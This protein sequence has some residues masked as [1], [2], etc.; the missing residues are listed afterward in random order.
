[1]RMTLKQYVDP[2]ARKFS[3]ILNL[4]KNE[5]EKAIGEEPES[6]EMLSESQKTDKLHSLAAEVVRNEADLGKIQP[7]LQALRQAIADPNIRNIGLMGSYGAGKSTIMKTFA[8]QSPEHKYLYLS[9]ATLSLKNDNTELGK[10]RDTNEML[11]STLVKQMIYKSH[12]TRMPHSRINRLTYLGKWKQNGLL[13]CAF[14]LYCACFYRLN[15]LNIQKHSNEIRQRLNARIG[16]ELAVWTQFFCI[17]VVMVCAGILLYFGCKQ[18]LSKLRITELTIFK[19]VKV[20]FEHNRSTFYAHLDEILSFFALMKYDVVV[21]EDLD[22]F[23]NVQVFEH[24][25]ELNFLLNEYEGIKRKITFIYAVKDELFAKGFAANNVS[26]AQRRT[27]FFDYIIPIAPVLNA[28][29]ARNFLLQEFAPFINNNSER[30]TFVRDVSIYIDDMRILKNMLAEYEILANALGKHDRREFQSMFS[31]VVY[32]VLCP[33]DYAALLKRKGILYEII[34][35]DETFAKYVEEELQTQVATLKEVEHEQTLKIEKYQNKRLT[36]LQMR[37]FEKIANYGELYEPNLDKFGSLA[38]LMRY[39]LINDLINDEYY[40]YMVRYDNVYLSKKDESFLRSLKSGYRTLNYNQKIDDIETIIENLSPI[41]YTRPG[42]VIRAII[43]SY[44]GNNEDIV[45]TFLKYASNEQYSI[46]REILCGDEKGY[47]GPVDGGMDLRSTIKYNG[48]EVLFMQRVFH[49]HENIVAVMKT[50]FN[51]VEWVLWLTAFFVLLQE[52]KLVAMCQQEDVK[53]FIEAHSELLLL[54]QKGRF[55]NR[56]T[57]IEKIIDV[58][59]KADIQINAFDFSQLDEEAFFHVIEQPIFAVNFAN[60]SNLIDFYNEVTG[61]TLSISLQS[62]REIDEVLA[63]YM[64]EHIV[65]YAEDVLL[66]VDQLNEVEEDLIT[67]I[68]VSAPELVSQF[69]AKNEVQIEDLSKIEG[70][71]NIELCCKYDAFVPT[72]ENIAFLNARD[73]LIDKEKLARVLQFIIDERELQVTYLLKHLRQ[74]KIK[75]EKVLGYVHLLGTDYQQIG[76]VNKRPHIAKSAPNRE[77]IDFLAE[78]GLISSSVIKDDLIQV[79]NKR[80]EKSKK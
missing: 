63:Q 33:T 18:V 24:L 65:D 55:H 48:N 57:P 3:A 73:I 62:L 8:D 49:Q 60:I 77:L 61:Q 47:F 23:D 58:F 54:L 12:P 20:S 1:M 78:K 10:G 44:V 52:E 11:E 4:G 59:A 32:K 19:D 64:T 31:M 51:P 21:I 27:K 14:I 72:Y 26:S 22:R 6:N 71:V 25:R 46:L 35:S 43:D 40:K 7:Y 68:N 42:I 38:P 9:L 80:A 13:F 37:L 5:Q 69:L 74:D 79:M 15:V 39:L 56:E 66:E 76:V 34:H 29:N 70:L 41:D 16:P 30:K 36:A 45:Q 17:I 67:L 28:D 53:A 50:L 75:R 2:K